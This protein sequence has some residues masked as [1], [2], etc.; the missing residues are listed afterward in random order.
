MAPFQSFGWSALPGSVSRNWPKDQHGQPEKPVFLTHLQ[1]TDMADTV[2]VNML[3]AFGIVS[4]LVHPGD[5]SFGKVVM[6]MSGTG[7][8]LYVPE[9]DYEQAKLL[10][11]SESDDQLQE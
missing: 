3:S 1:S 9:C 4:F 7:S 11:E 6:G 5:G 2:T 10:M 8:D